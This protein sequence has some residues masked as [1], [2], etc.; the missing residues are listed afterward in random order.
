MVASRGENRKN[1]DSR[2]TCKFPELLLLLALSHDR[3]L[4]IRGSVPG[5][6]LSKARFI[7]GLGCR[8]LRDEQYMEIGCCHLWSVQDGQGPIKWFVAERPG[9]SE[10][11]I[12]N[13]PSLSLSIQVADKDVSAQAFMGHRIVQSHRNSLRINA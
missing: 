4:I 6:P 1:G 8:Q 12:V 9:W 3:V 10:A 5:Q 11:V 7:L 13:D 2:Q